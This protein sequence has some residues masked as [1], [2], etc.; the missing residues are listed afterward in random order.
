MLLDD[1]IRYWAERAT[2]TSTP[3]RW[4]MPPRDA[5]V[6]GLQLSELNELQLC[7]LRKRIQLLCVET[8]AK[9]EDEGKRMATKPSAHL[10]P[11][12]I[13]SVSLNEKNTLGLVTLFDDNS[14]WVR[15]F[16]DSWHCLRP[17][18]AV[19]ATHDKKSE[20]VREDR[21]WRWT[22]LDEDGADTGQVY[23]T[24]AEAE[25]AA[26]NDS[27]RRFT[28]VLVPCGD[29]ALAG[30]LA[31]LHRIIGSARRTANQQ[32]ARASVAEKRL[33]QITVI[34]AWQPGKS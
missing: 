34:S 12:Q 20:S 28:P 30:E 19:A 9:T 22:L 13:T 4:P 16:D 33:R 31:R 15:T 29:P 27:S 10:V 6:Y 17:A 3:W 8:K 11:K 24:R 25:T 14:I 1:W 7:Q 18:A 5:R 21:G 2:R 23:A 26:G 32:R